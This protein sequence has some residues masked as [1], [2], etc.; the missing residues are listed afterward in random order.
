VPNTELIKMS[1]GFLFFGVVAFNI[2]IIALIF[3]FMPSHREISITH[4]SI[5][6][7]AIIALLVTNVMTI[8]SGMMHNMLIG[9]FH[10]INLPTGM[11]SSI[12]TTFFYAGVVAFA[13]G[14]FPL[15]IMAIANSHN[16]SD[17]PLTLATFLGTLTRWII[18]IL[19]SLIL[20]NK[21]LFLTGTTNFA[22]IGVFFF[23]V[24]TVMSEIIQC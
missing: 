9:N 20:L 23:A 11:D 22:L 1:R 10:H 4:V 15:K 3:N 8:P 5:K 17:L 6:V 7:V 19:A 2:G 18:C 16:R 14:M 24:T 21:E 12:A 13:E